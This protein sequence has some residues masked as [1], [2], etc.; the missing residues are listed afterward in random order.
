MKI[1]LE[2][3]PRERLTAL[4]GDALSLIELLAICLGSGTRGVSVLHLAEKL[5]AKFGNLSD[6]IEASLSELTQIKGIGRVKAIQLKAIFALVKRLRKPT[7][8]AK[9]PLSCPEDAYAVIAP[10]IEGIKQEKIALLLRN[11]KGEIFHHEI[12]CSGTLSEVMAHPRVVFHH[13]SLHYAYSFIL[14]HNHPSGDP[15]PSESDFELT[16]LIQTI[17]RLME[18]RLD[19]HLVI[20]RGTFVS[21]WERGF[22]KRSFY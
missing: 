13:V 4:S 10:H 12:V 7:G 1:P 17:G 6:L 5:V 9:C 18:V 2:E 14:V 8:V 22:F 15:E 3:R 21:F 20:G 16:R 11:V 19:D